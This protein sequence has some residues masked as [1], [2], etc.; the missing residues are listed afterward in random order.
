[1]RIKTFAVLLTTALAVAATA[2]P[3]EARDRGRG[4]EHHYKYDNRYNHDR[5]YPPRGYKVPALPKGY[6]T[7]R[8][9]GSRYYFH[10]GIWYRPSGPRFVVVAPPIGVIVPFLPPFYTTV[11]FGGFPYYYADHAYYRWVPAERGYVVSEPPA[12]PEAATT[13]QPDH[14][15]LFVYPTRGQSEQQQAADR[16]ECHHWAVGE[17]GFDPTQPLGGVPADQAVSKR[18]DYQRAETA[19]LEARGY[20][21]K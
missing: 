2:F 9:R 4:G 11:W 3:A 18:A 17:T 12:R 14:Q 8:Y 21:V 1:M 15:E 5:Y 6:Y 19:C 10:G 7:A 16:Y 13:T 20:S